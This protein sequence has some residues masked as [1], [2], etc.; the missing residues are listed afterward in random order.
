M[1]II[2]NPEPPAEGG[3]W[4]IWVDGPPVMAGRIFILGPINM[5]PCSRFP[6]IAY[7]LIIWARSCP[8]ARSINPCERPPMPA[9]I[10][11]IKNDSLTFCSCIHF[12][13]TGLPSASLSSLLS[14]TVMCSS[15]TWGHA[16]PCLLVKVVHVL[17][18]GF[19]HF[20]VTGWWSLWEC[21]HRHLRSWDPTVKFQISMIYKWEHN[22]TSCRSI[23]VCDNRSSSLWYY[24]RSDPWI[25]VRRSIMKQVQ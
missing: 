25:D 6:I 8:S 4:I 10:Y 20:L 17:H 7:G 21:L 3:F 19:W 9:T 22:R 5:L 11:S 13:S 1:P 18:P 16:Q 15:Y 12:G 2:P 24:Q 14:K 23:L